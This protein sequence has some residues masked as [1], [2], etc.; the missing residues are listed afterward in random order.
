LFNEDYVAEIDPLFINIW[1]ASF[2][3]KEI[4]Y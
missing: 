1:L 3:L 2:D 4:Q